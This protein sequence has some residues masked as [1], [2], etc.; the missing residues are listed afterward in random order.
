M[1]FKLVGACSYA[2]R[3]RLA[4]YLIPPKSFYKR[5]VW[6]IMRRFPDALL[7]WLRRRLR[8]V[9]QHFCSGK[10]VCNLAG[11]YGFP[12]EVH[13]AAW[14]SEPM[15]KCFE[16]YDCSVPNGWHELLTNMYGDYMT[17]PDESERHGHSDGF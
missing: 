17:L 7:F 14:F 10:R 5:L 8:A 16:G 11:R 1:Y 4:N 6:E 9:F 3:T 13:S 15:T 2:L 12:G